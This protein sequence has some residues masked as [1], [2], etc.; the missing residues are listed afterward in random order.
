MKK[1]SPIILIFGVIVSGGLIF[2]FYICPVR[3]FSNRVLAQTTGITATVVVL[4]C[5]NNQK[6][7]SEQCDGSDLAGETC[8]TRGY[9]GGTLSCKTDCTFNVS[10]CTTDA[11]PPSGGG[12]GGGGFYVPSETE[13]RVVLK[14]KAYPGAEI[15]I[16]KDGQV[17]TGIIADSQA[18]FKT[19]FTTLT[20][21]I[22]TFGV[23]AEDKQGRK[24]ITF[25][26]TINVSK[27]MTT[28]ISGIFIPPT[29]ELEKI[30][31][32][33]GEILNILGS[34]VPESEVNVHIESS[35][36]I[37]K[38]TDADDKGDWDF[39]FD[40]KILD[41]GAHTARAKAIAPDNLLSTY[42]STLVFVVGGKEMKILMK[43]GDISADERINLVDF[44]ILL[45]NWG[46]PK[47]PAADL[48]DDNKVDLQD[49]SIMMYYWTG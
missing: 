7:G 35:E 14:G 9:S 1:N 19:T 48:N 24:S 6:D 23:W 3:N 15:T 16:L 8:V 28:T 44:S 5:G 29:I 30:R 25:S 17:A 31:V 10:G 46:E 34:T 40:T 32:F 43:K 4:V 36:K 21:G 27:N 37:I 38:R 11:P 22:Y 42:S 12:G 39:A 26:F 47:N 18:N 20:A 33:K 45:Y 41:E 2:G 49:F 13:T